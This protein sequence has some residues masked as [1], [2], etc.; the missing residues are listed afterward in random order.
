VR[1]IHVNIEETS[2]IKSR[3]D[4]VTTQLQ[5]YNNNKSSF[6]AAM[7]QEGYDNEIIELLNKLS[8]PEKVPILRD[9]DADNGD[10]EDDDIVVNRFNYYFELIVNY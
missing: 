1:R 8:D 7:G 10:E 3:N 6:V 4:L 9:K 5:L 2:L